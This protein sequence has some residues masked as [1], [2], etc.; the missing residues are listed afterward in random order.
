MTI[1][2]NGVQ[3]LENGK[4]D[5]F[6]GFIPADGVQI[7]VDGFPTTSFPLD[8][9]GGPAVSGPGGLLDRGARSRTIRS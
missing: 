2:F 8:E 9:Y 5:A 3:N 4:V 7:E 1:G 6:T